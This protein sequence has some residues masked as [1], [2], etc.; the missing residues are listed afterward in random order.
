MIIL[1]PNPSSDGAQN[2]ITY[3]AP[4]RRKWNISFTV[5][6]WTRL[7][8]GNIPH[9]QRFWVSAGH[10]TVF[11]EWD[12]SFVS[13]T[14]L[15][16]IFLSL[17][18]PMGISASPFLFFLVSKKQCRHRY[19]KNN[20]LLTLIAVKLCKY[21]IEKILYLKSVTEGIQ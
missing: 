11:Q 17:N 15:A 19:H 10:C 21:S 12:T 14:N 18:F 20:Q 13:A 1:H 9:S 16:K 8:C 2:N 5:S 4:N 7:K 3:M 6:L